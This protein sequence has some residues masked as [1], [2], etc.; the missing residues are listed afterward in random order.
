MYWYPSY[1]E[2]LVLWKKRMYHGVASAQKPTVVFKL[3]V[4][5]HDIWIFEYIKDVELWYS[6]T[7]KLVELIS[8]CVFIGEDK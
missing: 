4:I 7:W 6:L 1:K 5:Q 8:K 3:H 2:G